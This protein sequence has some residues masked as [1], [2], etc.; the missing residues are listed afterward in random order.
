[1]KFRYQWGNQAYIYIFIYIY[2]T[3]EVTEAILE[4]TGF[5]PLPSSA[6]TTCHCC[7][8]GY[9]CQLC[10]RGLVEWGWQPGPCWIDCGNMWESIGLYN[11][12][13]RY[14]QI[15]KNNAPWTCPYSATFYSQSLA[16]G[17]G[18]WGVATWQN[19]LCSCWQKKPKASSKPLWKVT[20]AELLPSFVNS[21]Q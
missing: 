3:L 4:V 13:I 15:F 2:V 1:M 6:T 19:P 11:L 9:G 5:P 8:R 14:P 21:S 20:A 17:L 16:L 12:K 7:W 18:L 10:R